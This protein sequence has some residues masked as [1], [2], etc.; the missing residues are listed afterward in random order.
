MNKSPLPTGDNSGHKKNSSAFLWLLLALLVFVAAAFAG[1]SLFFYHPETAALIGPTANVTKNLRPTFSPT[2]TLVADLQSATS[3]KT[4]RPI[5]LRQRI[6]LSLRTL[7]PPPIPPCPSH[8]RIRQCQPLRLTL[9]SLP[10]FLL[11]R[12]LPSQQARAQL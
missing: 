1:W 10:R 5:P 11:P 9:V 2:P 4:T 12:T 8:P 7:Q 3:E 6:R